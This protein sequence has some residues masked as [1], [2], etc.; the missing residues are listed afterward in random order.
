MSPD[1]SRFLELIDKYLHHLASEEETAEL[2]LLLQSRVYDEDL[3]QHIGESW[4]AEKKEMPALNEHRKKEIL[5]SIF[6][7][8]Y[9]LET[10]PKHRGVIYRYR[11]AAVACLALIIALGSLWSLLQPEQQRPGAVAITNTAD[12]TIRPGTTQASLTL[13]DGSTIVLNDRPQGELIKQGST[14]VIKQDSATLGYEG[15]TGSAAYNILRTPRGGQYNLVLSDGSRVWL[16]AAT[17]LRFPVSFNGNDRTVEL[18]G[19]AYFEVAHNSQKP[20]YVK[21]R[22]GAKVEVTGTR[23]N[24][25]AYEDEPARQ[26]TLLE[27]SINITTGNT[28]KKLQPGQQAIVNSGNISVVNKTDPEESIAWKNGFISFKDANIQTIMRE[29]SRWYDVKVEYRGDIPSR[30]FTGSLLRSASLSDL[31]H[32]LELSKIKFKIE[33]RTIIV[34]G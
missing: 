4:N 1:S 32:I 26:A 14:S 21:I 12:S 2:F 25:M 13:D 16:N 7:S 30:F 24:V 20:F 6:N 33:G 29:A 28:V 27:G 3:E 17:S 19:E 10:T 22:D 34:S 9:P 23:F 31:L 18:D 11:W 15:I 8:P 5:S